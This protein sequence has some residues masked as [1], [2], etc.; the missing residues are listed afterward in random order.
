MS[1][2][3][4][5]HC[6]GPELLVAGGGADPVMLYFASLDGLRPRRA[7]LEALLDEEELARAARFRF[8]HDR[9][10]YILGHGM[11][12][13]VLGRYLETEPRAVRFARE[14]F[15]KP[16][17]PDSRVR[18]N[19]SDTKDAVLIAVSAGQTIGVDLETMARNVDHRAVSDH[20]F[21]AEEVA[22][23]AAATDEKRRFLELWT[24]KESVLKASGVGIMEDLRMLRV[25]EP[26][27][28]L[29]IAHEDFQRLAAPAYHVRTWHVGERHIISLATDSAVGSV[30][31][32]RF[33]R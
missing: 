26:E 16:Y 6:S 20:Y 29:V 27:N 18:F 32:E 15:G 7:E 11:M 9:E 31:F 3:L 21:T 13:E 1:R 25:N 12:R 5:V 28:H 22:D 30:G 24:R 23:I 8:D 14:E 17:V 2:R 19:F 10:R 4:I 33:A